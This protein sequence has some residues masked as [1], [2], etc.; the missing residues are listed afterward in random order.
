M[1][2]RKTLSIDS[3]N[4]NL[5]IERMNKKYT[6]EESINKIRD[7]IVEGPGKRIKEL[8]MG[9]A[10]HVDIPISLRRISNIFDVNRSVDI[11]DIDGVLKRGV[12]GII[13]DFSSMG[14]NLTPL[15]QKS[16]S[17]LFSYL[18]GIKSASDNAGDALISI[19]KNLK[20]GTNL[21]LNQ[22]IDFI[23]EV[24]KDK[25]SLLDEVYPNKTD[26][27]KVKNKNGELNSR[28]AIESRIKNNFLSLDVDDIKFLYKNGTYRVRFNPKKLFSKLNLKTGDLVVWNKNWGKGN[29]YIIPFEDTNPSMIKD[30]EKNGYKTYTEANYTGIEGTIPKGGEVTAIT[31]SKGANF[32]LRLL[33]GA[34][35]KGGVGGFW[36]RTKSGKRLFPAYTWVASSKLMLLIIECGVQDIF[37]KQKINR[38]VS[39]VE[40]EY[41]YTFADCMFGSEYQTKDGLVSYEPVFYAWHGYNIL[42]PVTFQIVFGVA[43]K[44]FKEVLLN[45][46][47]NRK[48]EYINRFNNKVDEMMG[49][50]SIR[51]VL[52]FDTKLQVEGS[53]NEL[54][55]DED[56]TMYF[57][58][59]K[60]ATGIDYNENDVKEFILN[61]IDG[62]SE[63][64]LDSEKKRDEVRKDINEKIGKEIQI[65]NEISVEGDTNY[66]IQIENLKELFYESAK[67]KKGK[68]INEKLIA[69]KKE[70]DGESE[71]MKKLCIDLE[72]M[73]DLYSL[74]GWEPGES[75]EGLSDANCIDSKEKL[76][77]IILVFSE[78]EATGYEGLNE[79]NKEINCNLLTIKDSYKN[80]CINNQGTQVVD[81]KKEKI[82]GVI[83]TITIPVKDYT[84]QEVKEVSGEYKIVAGF[85]DTDLLLKMLSMSGSIIKDSSKGI[86]FLNDNGLEYKVGTKGMPTEGKF[87]VKLTE[88]NLRTLET[89]GK[90]GFCG[91]SAD[92]AKCINTL[93]ETIKN[94]EYLSQSM[95]TWNGCVYDDLWTLGT[96][97]N[98]GGNE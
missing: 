77:E 90:G 66:D 62:I 51:G 25:P 92:K 55:E 83:T 64:E 96:D 78:K 56:V 72:V 91:G 74:E 70:Y 20:N 43:G 54:L 15:D 50:L 45:R 87:C 1:K 89:Y 29:Y 61:T 2:N 93:I 80:G 35:K 52:N 94:D 12:D 32:F 8:I 60:W 49:G 67:M 30:L 19:N 42:I 10:I 16:I 31:Q 33:V 23:D 57:K 48:E 28:D 86:K 71:E 81:V 39:G 38:L 76:E 82:N 88:K 46:L 9:G 27:N 14:K 79:F 5:L 53:V 69:H 40:K 65:N 26:L 84:F 58:V 95:D 24:Y 17:N 22:R 4:F 63:A 34:N 59:I 97:V 73:L 85:D 11:A 37:D 7:L 75:L 68:I 18:E 21:D 13:E 3:K 36:F 47:E 41:S 6:Y 44:V 98:M